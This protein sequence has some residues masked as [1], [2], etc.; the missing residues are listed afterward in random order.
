M[1]AS[2]LQVFV[3]GRPT[4]TLSTTDGFEHN[5]TYYPLARSEDFVSLLM[6][7]RPKS[8]TWPTLHPFFQMSL[9]EGFLLGILKEQ[10]GPLLGGEPLDL[11][12]VVGQNTVGRVQVSAEATLLDS[13]R[14]L[15]VEGLLHSANSTQLFTELLHTYAASGISGVVP[16]F[17]TPETQALFRKGS[18]ST[19]RHI[20]KTG[21]ERL[22]FIALNEH[23]CMEVARRTG[24][25][26]PATQISDDGQ[27]LV[28]ERFDIDATGVR[29]GFEDCCSL[30][31]LSPD[32]KYQST[33]ERVARLVAEHVPTAL[34]PEAREQLAITLLLTYA[35][36]NAD[37]H[38]KNLGLLYSNLADIQVAPI[39]DMLTIRAYDSYARNDPGMY[40]GG[41]KSWAPGKAFWNFMQQSLGVEPKHQRELVARVC[42]AVA[43]SFPALLRHIRNTP[44]FSDTGG[45]M[46]R[47]WHAGM[48]RLAARCSTVVPDFMA[49]AEKKGFSWRDPRGLQRR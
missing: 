39:Y 32:D 5:L 6:P 11:L 34:L 1:S 4:A 42:A 2:N 24:A 31:G 18:L 44:G 46:V 20:I 3:G 47:E 9:P 13:V 10:L 19:E 8:W 26:V 30:L 36:G 15:D 48:Q 45:R 12:A 49:E 27:V 22:P 28:V 33:W 35:L 14:R 21:S 40:V 43:E 16:K 41:V 17:L 37:C 23:L 38:T 7:V 25:A 29:L